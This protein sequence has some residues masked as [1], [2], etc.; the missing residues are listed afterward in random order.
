MKNNHILLSI[1]FLLF[2]LTGCNTDNDR[3]SNPPPDAPVEEETN[4]LKTADR[5]LF[6]FTSFDLEVEYENHRSFEIK[7]D[8]EIDGMEVELEDDRT[9]KSQSGDEAFD[10]IE[11][12]FQTFTFDSSTPKDEVIA[13]VLEAFDLDTN[14]QKF[15]LDVDFSD[16]SEKDYN[17]YS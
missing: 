16:G 7:Y 12:I 15:E 6:A 2:L 9:N 10:Q 5:N 17:N 4:K 8:N 3:V 1:I 13:E 11:P 14:Y